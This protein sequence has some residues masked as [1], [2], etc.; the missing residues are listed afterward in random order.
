[1]FAVRWSVSIYVTAA[2]ILFTLAFLDFSAGSY[3]GIFMLDVHA[4]CGFRLMLYLTDARVFVPFGSLWISQWVHTSLA[5]YI[6]ISYVCQ[7]CSGFYLV[8]RTCL[9][10]GFRLIWFLLAVNWLNDMIICNALYRY[11][12]KSICDCFFVFS[13]QKTGQSIYW[14]HFLDFGI[15]LDVNILNVILI[16]KDE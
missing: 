7:M 3:F 15:H 6:G 12:F 1:M 10:C 4:E 5:V 9:Y 11:R 14:I 2:I 16:S 8:D 13:F